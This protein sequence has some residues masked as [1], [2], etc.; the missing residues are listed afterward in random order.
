[1]ND[2]GLDEP[3]ANASSEV[4]DT[5]KEQN[6]QKQEAHDEKDNH[7]KTSDHGHDYQSPAFSNARDQSY[8][9]YELPTRWWYASTGFP[10]V[11]GTFGPMA[12]AFSICALVQ[13]WRVE[14]PPGGTEEHGIDIPDPK[15]LIAVNAVSLVCALIAN[16]SLLLNMAK[17]MPFRIAQ[18]I[19]ILGFWSSSVLLTVLVGYAAHDFHAP[20]VQKQALTQAYYYACWAAGLYQLISLMMCVTVYGAITHHYSSEFKLT[21]AQRT[22]MLQTISFLTYLLLGALVYSKIEGWKYL[23]AVY[24]ADFTLLTVGIGGDLVPTTHLGRGLLFPFSIGGIVILGLVVSSIRSMVLDR[25]KVKLHA[26]MTEKMRRRLV[27]QVEQTYAEGKAK[28][29]KVTGLNNNLV[30]RLTLDP[31]DDPEQEFD[32]RR[33]E[34]EA[35]RSVQHLTSQRQKWMNL[36]VSTSA[37]AMLWFLGALVFWQTE[38][39]NQGWTYF[40]ALYFSW[41]SLLT[42]GY[43]D[44]APDSNAGRPFF[45]FWSLLAI[46]SLTILI[47]DMGDTVVK[48]VKDLTIWLGEISILPSNQGSAIERLQYGIFKT[49]RVQMSRSHKSKDEEKGSDNDDASSNGRGPLQQPGLV[50]LFRVPKD[51]KEH[52]QANDMADRISRDFEESE[53]QEEREAHDSGDRL[54][55]FQHHYRRTLIAEIRRVYADSTSSTPKHYDYDEW[56]YFLKLL[57]EDESS[58]EFHQHARVKSHAHGAQTNNTAD[59]QTESN[60]KPGSSPPQETEISKWSWIGPR[61]PL[62][63]RGSKSEPEWLIARLFER[64]EGSLRNPHEDKVQASTEV[65]SSGSST[66][67]NAENAA[68]LR[69]TANKP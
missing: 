35:M 16:M 38:G 64:L 50:K 54:A 59:D 44:F 14:V 21:M 62:M 57:G 23:D 17:R 1:M 46:P 28:R 29:R 31:A 55:E 53:E 11:T 32:R 10:L 12:N 37:F 27:K 5:Y 34:F 66:N 67:V 20:G 36:F 19:T 42:I 65:Q 45:V 56:A 25:G 68:R 24:W 7:S 48:G 3:I 18:P 9:A 22:L 39:R 52:D 43:G 63:T 47:S 15:W 51:G 69:S 49:A 30:Q 60:N 33:A 41:T 26:R 40:V 8:D 2:P 13:N 58:S 4:R 6:D 61:S